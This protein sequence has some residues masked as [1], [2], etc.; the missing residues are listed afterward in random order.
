MRIR[1]IHF[2]VALL[3]LAVLPRPARAQA[4]AAA[5]ILEAI[6]AD[7][8]HY[9]EAQIIAETGLKV[10]ETVTKDQLQEAADRLGQLGLFTKVNYDYRTR[11]DGLALA[12]HLVDA[13]RVAVLFDNIPWFSDSELGDAVRKTVPFFDGTAPEQGNLLDRIGDSVRELLASH[14]LNVAVEHEVIANPL[15]D[16]NVVQYRINGA[17]VHIAK[18]EFS[19]P[20][21][22]TSRALQQR[23]SEIVGKPY[24]RLAI[25]LFLAEQVRPVYLQQGYLR[26]QLGPPDIRLT[27]NPNRPLPDSLPVFIPVKTG[28]VYRWNGV[29]WKGNSAIPAAA[30]TGVLGMRLGDVAN[31]YAIEAAWEH[32]REEYGRHGYLE[33]KVQP[34]E[35]F[36]DATQKV[37]YQV[38]VVEGQQHHYGEMVLTGVSL[39][40][41]KL[42]RAKWPIAPGEVFDKIKY[43]E[44]LIKLQKHST[45][46][47]GELPI[48]YDEV[49]HWL[50]TDAQKGIVDVLLDFK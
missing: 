30:L 40:A 36:D 13:P 3:T 50:R 49:G 21:T 16:G 19:D 2:G 33:A 27:G 34:R 37:S 31:G 8:S 20:A 6:H 32:A 25:D 28:A 42:I 41:E 39:A 29:Q 10:G 12:L 26:V 18:L 15:G 17:S 45:E 24:S 23:L 47:F 43:E 46:I 5:A 35:V 7:G 4:Q 14:N 22:E 48:H 9:P 11:V 1:L 38:S 44:F